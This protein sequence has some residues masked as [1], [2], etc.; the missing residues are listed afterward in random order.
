AGN[1]ALSEWVGKVRADH[2]LLGR[3]TQ[4]WFRHLLATRMRGDI[5]AAMDQ[6]GW[7]DERSV[8][9]YVMDVTEHRRRLVNELD[10]APDSDTPLTR[11][12]GGR[13]EN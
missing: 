10:N 7:I 4:H 1:A 9:G 2:R 6:G 12:I 3:I 5:K 13:K 11:G 8:M